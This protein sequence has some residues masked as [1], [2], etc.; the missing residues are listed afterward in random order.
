[1]LTEDYRDRGGSAVGAL[2]RATVT[3][4]P[5]YLKV[6]YFLILLALVVLG[7]AWDA[8]VGLKVLVGAVAVIP[9]VVADLVL[10]HRRSGSPSA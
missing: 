2:R 1:M 9:V 7:F 3:V 5:R 4:M 8:S 10:R 6:V